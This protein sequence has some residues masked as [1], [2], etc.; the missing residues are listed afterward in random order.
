MAEEFL[1]DSW[2]FF[3]TH[4]VA[5]ALIVLPITVTLEL[6]LVLHEQFLAS[7]EFVLSG[8]F[9]PLV[10]IFV[11]YPIYRGAV[12]FYVASAI[13]GEVLAAPSLWKLSI[14][15]WVPYAI[16]IVLSFFA[17]AFGILAFVLPALVL[18]AR[19]AFTDFDLLL[20]RSGPLR[21]I[22]NSWNATRGYAGLIFRGFAVITLVLFVPSMLFQT[23][24]SGTGVLQLIL[25]PIYNVLMSLLSCLYLIY[26]Y[27]VYEFS[28]TPRGE[29]STRGG[30]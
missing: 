7:E 12:V 18:S 25:M 1:K 19:L 27:R 29:D 17:F 21:A 16:L 15:F 30:A 5:L 23:L 26:A 13:S 4:F 9:L 10:F 20:N 24:L 6:V 28:R 2:S 22:G 14:R 11:A 3:K 8:Q